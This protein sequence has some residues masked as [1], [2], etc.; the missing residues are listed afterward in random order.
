MTLW[1]KIGKI[2]VKVSNVR[3]AR[4]SFEQ[5][6]HITFSS[7]KILFTMIQA[8]IMIC[9]AHTFCLSPVIGAEL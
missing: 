8:V 4:Y 9:K 5:V 6:R 2:A 7:K 3:L 1:Y